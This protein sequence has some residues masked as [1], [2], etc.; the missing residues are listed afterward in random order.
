MS[1]A[2]RQ[3]PPDQSLDGHGGG[4]LQGAPLVHGARH[5]RYRS[6]WRQGYVER[7]CSWVCSW[8]GAKSIDIKNIYIEREHC[9]SV[10]ETDVLIRYVCVLLVCVVSVV[11]VPYLGQQSR[12]EPPKEPL[13][14][15]RQTVQPLEFSGLL[16]RLDQL[17]AI[18]SSHHPL[19]GPRR[20]PT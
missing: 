18:V 11:I 15:H 8:E 3:P 19:D 1:P 20:V 9:S 2:L 7:K 5:L 4:A 12:S 13:N 10:D 6:V 14:H 16:Q 17:A